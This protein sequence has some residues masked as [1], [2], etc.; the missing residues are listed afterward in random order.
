MTAEDLGNK[1][2][3]RT[4]A[5]YGVGDVGNALVNSA[6]Q[7]FLLISTPTRRCWRPRWW[8]APC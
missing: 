6:M 1:L 2:S 5:F 8:A 7:F 4:K 3:T